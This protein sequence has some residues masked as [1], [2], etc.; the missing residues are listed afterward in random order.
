MRYWNALAFLQ[1]SLPLDEWQSLSLDEISH[2]L[3]CTRRN[4][5]LLIKRLTSEKIIEW[6]SGVGRGNLPLV[7]RLADL[8]QRLAAH[9][10]HLIE[11]GQIESALKLISEDKRNKFLSDYLSQYQQLSAQNHILQI[12]FYRG[13]HDLDPIGINRRTEHHI[14]S[15][16]YSSLLKA[17]LDGHSFQ[18]DLA[19]SWKLDG[20]ELTVILRKNLSFHDGSPILAADVKIHFDRLMNSSNVSKALFQFID[21]VQV[22]TP[23]KLKFI[24]HSLPSLLPKLLAH[25]AMGITKVIDGKVYGSGSF[26][27]KEQ[28][29]RRTLL[30]VNPHYH[31]YK[32]W[33]DGIEIWNIGDNAKAFDLNSDVVHGSHLKQTREGFTTCHQWE[34][35]CVHAMLNPLRHHWMKAKSNRQWLQTVL[36]A[37]SYPIGGDCEQLAYAKGMTSP[38]TSSNDLHTPQEILPTSDRPS[39]PLIIMTYQLGTHIATAEQIRLTLSTLGIESELTVLEYP[40]FN[41]QATLSQADIMVTGEVFSEDVEFSWLGWLLCTNSNEA[42][43]NATNRAWRDK[44]ITAAMTQTT[45]KKR[46]KALENIEKKLIAKAIYQPLYHVK[47]DLNI[48]DKISAPELLANGWIDFNQITM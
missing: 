1:H 38:P 28:T 37:M 31:G 4:A 48:S 45:E 2:V 44:Q 12:P 25:G 36:Q 19:H 41:Q 21:D 43:L 24:S 47:Q 35:G 26:I 23:Y 40:Q 34:L 9:A 27:L 39:S 32:P 5:Q 8:E 33:I 29:P 46:L 16:L 18:G 6:Q 22:T 13:T 3:S 42:C 15:Y 30:V 10:Q 11:Q 7:K 20:N 17:S 14:A